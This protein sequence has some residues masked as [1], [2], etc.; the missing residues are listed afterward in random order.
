MPPGTRA[1][2]RGRPQALRVHARVR[3]GVWARCACACFRAL[4]TGRTRGK[5]AQHRG[6]PAPRQRLLGISHPTEGN[7]SPAGNVPTPGLGH[8]GCT[9][10][11]NLVTPEHMRTGHK[12][13]GLPRATCRTAPTSKSLWTGPKSTETRFPVFLC[14]AAGTGVTAGR[15]RVGKALSPWN[16]WAPLSARTQGAVPPCPCFCAGLLALAAQGTT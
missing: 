10:S 3:R 16:A 4:G 7:P 11:P 8:S 14:R 6:H 1:P 12:D 2:C 9:R 15:A 13:A 5:D